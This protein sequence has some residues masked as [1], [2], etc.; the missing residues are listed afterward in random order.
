[1]A[2]TELALLNGGHKQIRSD[3]GD[4]RDFLLI[5]CMEQEWTRTVRCKESRQTVTKKHADLAAAMPYTIYYIFD[6]V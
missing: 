3:P 4:E 1:V 5:N 6:N 2:I